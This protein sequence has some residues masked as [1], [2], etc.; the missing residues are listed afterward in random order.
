[1]NR[2]RIGAELNPIGELQAV[3]LGQALALSNEHPSFF[4]SPLKH[5]KQTALIGTA[6]YHFVADYYD[7]KTKKELFNYYL[8]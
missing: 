2:S 3:K 6:Q 8:I 7:C 5:A 4:H 1:M